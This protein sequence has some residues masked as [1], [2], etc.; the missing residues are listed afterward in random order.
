MNKPIYFNYD[1]VN[2]MTTYNQTV[3]RHF[4]PIDVFIME[5]VMSNAY[6]SDHQIAHIFMTSERTVKR[7]INKLCDF[8]LITKH[9][10]QNNAKSITLNMDALRQFLYTYHY[11]IIEQFEDA[12]R[13]EM[14]G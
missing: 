2:A 6:V 10:A 14:Y 1:I 5:A 3:K 11:S 7:S 8:G 12:L 13:D 9:I 4:L